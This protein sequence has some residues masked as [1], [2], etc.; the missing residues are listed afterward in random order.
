VSA[1]GALGGLGL[2]TKTNN[3]W[4]RVVRGRTRAIGPFLIGIE[5]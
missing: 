5:N 1:I 2:G 4:L 3:E